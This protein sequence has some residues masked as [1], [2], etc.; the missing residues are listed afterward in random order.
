ML[1]LL[2]KWHSEDDPL[3]REQVDILISLLDGRL[4]EKALEG[5]LIVCSRFVD[6]LGHH[7]TKELANIFRT[8]SEQGKQSLHR[9]LEYMQEWVGGMDA[10]E[11]KYPV[12]VI[13]AKPAFPQ[14]KIIG[15]ED[16]S[17]RLFRVLDSNSKVYP[18][19]ECTREF[20]MRTGRLPSV[21]RQRH[22]V[23][24]S[25]A[26]YHWCSYSAWSDPESTRDAL[27][28]LSEWS[29]C[30]LRVS[31]LTEKV[32]RSAY[33]AFNGDRKDPSNSTL[34]F[35]K[36]YYEPH[37]QDHPPHSGGGAQ[38]AIEGGPLVDVMEQWDDARQEWQ[39]IYAA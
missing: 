24:R 7:R 18:T 5:F 37:A 29:D 33:V 6:E 14:F 31:V 30:K 9:S 16:L 10:Y 26:R 20:I 19:G 11:Q 4:T 17:D 3:T 8:H 34:K 13:P 36:Y 21:P 15:I 28:I 38:I 35:Y 12:T 32:K 25:K 1:G 2:T 23:R 27:Q 39:V 22:P